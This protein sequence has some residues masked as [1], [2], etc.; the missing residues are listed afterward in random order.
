MACIS[1][2]QKRAVRAC[3]QCGSEVT[4]REV[5]AGWQDQHIEVGS[6]RDTKG[7]GLRTPVPVPSKQAWPQTQDLGSMPGAGQIAKDARQKAVL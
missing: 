3:G 1:A 5:N 2:G 4:R 6:R 7:E